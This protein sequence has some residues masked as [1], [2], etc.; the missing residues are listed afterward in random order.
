MQRL[1]RKR[2]GANDGK[3]DRGD[4]GMCRPPPASLSV[5]RS[6]L[7]ADLPMRSAPTLVYCAAWVCA[8]L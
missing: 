8:Y 5:L 3:G 1:G 4:N 7:G 2:G 6:L